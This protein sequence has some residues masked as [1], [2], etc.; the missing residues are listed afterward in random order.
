MTDHATPAT[1]G[2]PPEADAATE[3]LLRLLA[4]AAFLVF[5]QGFMIAPLIPRLAQLF[6]AST[7]TVGLAVPAY[8]IPYG[9][10]TLIWGPLSDRFGRRRVIL[11]SLT[12]FVVLTAA[13]AAVGGANG[14]LA[15]RIVTAVGA[16]GVVPIS[17]ALIGDLFHPRRRGH[18]LGWLFGAMAGGTA[19]GSSAGALLEPVIGWRGL[20]LAVAALAVPILILLARH[21]E[22]LQRSNTP[23]ERAVRDVARG[24]LSLLADR[25]A[26]RTYG[27]VFVNA[28][29]HGGVY[30]WLGLY[31]TRRFGIGEAAIGLA[32]LGYGIPGFLFGP[33]IGRLADRHGRARLIP[34]GLATGAGAAGLLALPVPLVAAAATVALLSLGYDLTQPLLGGIVTELSPNRGQAMGLN[35]FT[36][37]IGTGAG[38]LA[39]QA[40]LTIGLTAG[41]VAFAVGAGLASVA[42]V[43]LFAGETLHNRASVGDGP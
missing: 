40:S 4:A 3:R 25:R 8:L 43:R 36:L 38:A 32:I 5:F 11:G 20:F 12:A 21:P 9:L 35:V 27:Y 7:N 41:L 18:A 22:L 30:T 26:R 31:F 42:A 34:L 17:L 37:F 29:L 16:S 14:F 15:A 24:Y 2:E 1:M 33:V 6:D 23:E 28:V 13:T 39:F 10:T 19:F